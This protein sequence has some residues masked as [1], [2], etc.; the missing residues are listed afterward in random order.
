MAETKNTGTAAAT[1]EAKEIAAKSQAAQEDKSK[2]ASQAPEENVKVVVPTSAKIPESMQASGPSP[3]H[4]SV[5]AP[6]PTSDPAIQAARDR[7]QAETEDD[8]E[9]EDDDL[10]AVSNIPPPVGK[11]IQTVVKKKFYSEEGQVVVPGKTYYFQ[12][13]EGQT[14]PSDVLEPVDPKLSSKFRREFKRRKQERTEARVLR[15]RARDQ[16]LYGGLVTTRGQRPSQ[17]DK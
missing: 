11:P 15:E 4:P 6:T 1:A 3:Q 10:D 17:T 9:N 14:F 13:R 8:L 12:L 2:T 16:M 7:A 5:D